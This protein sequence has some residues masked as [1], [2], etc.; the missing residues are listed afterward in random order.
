MTQKEKIM[1][2]LLAIQSIRN[3]AVRINRECGEYSSTAASYAKD[4]VKQCED[5]LRIL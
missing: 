4:I 2:S 5:L 1:K 3:T